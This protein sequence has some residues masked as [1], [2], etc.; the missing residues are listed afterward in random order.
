MKAVFIKERNFKLVSTF[1]IVV[2]HSYSFNHLSQWEGRNNSLLYI[3][4]PTIGG[5]K[6]DW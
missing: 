3:T 2:T 4:M 5:I 1:S 6:I